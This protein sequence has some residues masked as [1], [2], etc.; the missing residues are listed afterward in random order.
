MAMAKIKFPS[1]RKIMYAGATV[2]NGSFATT[3]TI[4]LPKDLSILNRRGYASTYKGTPLVYRCAVTVYP[5]LLDGSGYTYAQAADTRTTVKVL[6]V[7]N[8]W[9]MK[10][11]AIQYHKAREFMFKKA[12]IPK[13][14]RGAYSHEIRY[15]WYGANTSWSTPVDGDGAA[16]TGGTWD[17]SALAWAGD[18][19]FQLTLTG[20]GDNEEAD[21][22]SGTHLHIGHSYLLRRMNQLADTNP[23][24]EE[25][26][27]KFSILQNMPSKGS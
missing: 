11:A 22:F 20:G 8:N 4:S 5:S 2:S 26:P 1:E 9:V 6:G 18:N 19:S 25:G 12:G 21:K 10:N 7:Q 16:F 23:Q 24:T 17:Q 3:H 27:A 15:N 14:Q 13:K